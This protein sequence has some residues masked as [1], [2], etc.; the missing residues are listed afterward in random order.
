[1]GRKKGVVALAPPYNTVSSIHGD[2]IIFRWKQA[3]TD[4]VLS[5]HAWEPFSECFATLR[6]MVESLGDV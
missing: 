6:A 1:M 3:G 2:H 5:L 4:Y